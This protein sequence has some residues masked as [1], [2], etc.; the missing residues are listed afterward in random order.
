VV[1]DGGTWSG[2]S[3]QTV[4]GGE[5]VTINNPIKTSYLFTGWTISGTGSSMDGTTFTMG[6]EDTTITANWV[7][8][9]LT[10]TVNAAGGTWSGIT[11]QTIIS[12]TSVT[13]ANPTKAG[14][15]F[16]GWTV[17]GTGSSIDGTTFT[18]G[19]ADTTITANG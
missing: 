2:T 18:M 6:T 8:N 15:V 12:S 11:P 13:I 10:L 7:L 16:T 17:S 9:E 3:P 14:Y 5:S 4:A 1:T 19:T